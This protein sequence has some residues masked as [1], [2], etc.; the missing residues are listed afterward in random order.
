MTTERKGRTRL[1]GRWARV[2]WAV[3]LLCFVFALLSQPIT[4]FVLTFFLT[5]AGKDMP[6]GEKYDIGTHLGN[7]ASIALVLCV[8][9]GIGLQVF[10]KRHEES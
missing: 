7:L 5:L 4:I 6:F 9:L 3:A 1:L 2:A 10:A 8:L